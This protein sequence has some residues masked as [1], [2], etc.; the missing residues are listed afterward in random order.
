VEGDLIITAVSRMFLGQN[1]EK[2]GP[3]AARAKI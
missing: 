2:R 3:E 1:E